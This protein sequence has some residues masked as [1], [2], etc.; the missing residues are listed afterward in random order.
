MTT[1]DNFNW[2]LVSD[3]DVLLADDESSPSQ[4]HFFFTGAK[5]GQQLEHLLHLSRFSQLVLLVIGEDGLGKTSLLKEFLRHPQEGA[6]ITYVDASVLM[7]T[8]SVLETIAKQWDLPIPMGAD[9]NFYLQ[10]F[11]QYIQSGSSE[12]RYAIFVID[13]A[14]QLADETL[15]ALYAL[16]TSPVAAQI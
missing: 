14:G 6:D 11:V 3:D 7:D 15:S 1:P 13:N 2:Q 9:I 4:A 16:F 5:R 10:S 12:G 8:L